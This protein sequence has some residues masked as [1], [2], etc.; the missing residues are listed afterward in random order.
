MRIAIDDV[1]VSPGV[2]VVA[3]RPQ[4]APPTGNKGVRGSD[5]VPVLVELLLPAFAAFTITSR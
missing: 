2:K 1:M 3:W 5:H 4:T